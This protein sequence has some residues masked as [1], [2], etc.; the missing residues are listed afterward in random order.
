MALMVVAALGGCREVPTSVVLEIQPAAGVAL[1]ELRLSI[2]DDLGAAVSAERLPASGPPRLPDRVVLFPRQGAGTVRVLVRGL[3]SGQVLAEGAARLTLQPGS[4]VSASLALQAGRLPDLDGDGVPDLADNCPAQPNPDQRACAPSEAGAADR[5]ADVALVPDKPPPPDLPRVEAGSVALAVTAPLTGEIWATGTTHAI[6]WSSVGPV[7]AVNVELW[8]AGAKDR[9][10][11]SNQ[12][13][14]GS[15]SW[16]VPTLVEG[17]NYRIRVVDAQQPAVAALSPLFSITPWHYVLPVTVE[18]R[19]AQALTSYPVAITLPASFAYAHARADG[20]DLRAASQNGAVSFDL[21]LWTVWN[22][23][24]ISKV[25]VRLPQL[26]AGQKLTFYLFYGNT[27]AAT[28]SSATSTFPKRF[29]SSADLA[30]GGPQSYDWFE[31]QAGHTLTL[32]KGQPLVIHA[33]VI[34]LSGT[35]NGKAA[36][37]AGGP[38]NTAGVGPGGGGT[39]T[40]S[41][42]GGGGHGGAGGP[43]GYDGTETPGAG[44]LVNDAVSDTVDM[45]SGGGGGSGPALTGGPG[46]GALTLDAHTV[47]VTGTIDLSGASGVATT[48]G[49]GGGAGGGILFQTVDLDLGSATLELSGGKGG[50]G[51]GTTAPNGGGGGGGGRFKV[52]H[53]KSYVPPLVLKLDGGLGGTG[54]ATSPGQPGQL[55][56]GSSK[57]APYSDPTLAALG[58]EVKL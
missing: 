53:E 12:L 48:R 2:F 57:V 50:N 16:L 14:S 13:P 6:T 11:A 47:V 43:G 44:G 35:V 41:G 19:T 7:S 46:G 15:F 27:A 54:G 29:V 8:R 42:A 38:N 25:W 49:T 18:N 36:G 40:T 45:G 9:D 30:L 17:N 58:A 23:G 24:G 31:L 10:L 34:A 20:A 22:S 3:Q 51:A 39:S 21:S 56:T 33:R 55:G 4:Q 26:A 28:V 52:S 32:L 37:Y 1:D 5:S